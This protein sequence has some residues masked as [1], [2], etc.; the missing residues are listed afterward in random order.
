MKTLADIQTLEDP[1][2]EQ[3]FTSE[4]DRLC[5]VILHNDDVND[6]VHVIQSLMKVFG[7]SVPLAAKI[8]G[9]AHR[10]GHAIAEVEAR[11]LAHLHRGQLQSLGLIATVS[12]I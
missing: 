9:E 1:E 6:M 5:E 3:R 11:H 10:N 7:H 4:R 2:T 12:E 8:T